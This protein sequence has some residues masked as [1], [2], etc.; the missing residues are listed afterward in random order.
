MKTNLLQSMLSRNASTIRFYE[1]KKV[2]HATAANAAYAAENHALLDAQ[3]HL[4]HWYRRSINK[5]AQIQRAI[6][7]DIKA[8]RSRRPSKKHGKGLMPRNVG[9]C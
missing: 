4:I 5:L 6:K 1:E 7:E 9:E 3:V 2:E 8:S